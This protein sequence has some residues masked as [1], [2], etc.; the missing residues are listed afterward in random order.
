MRTRPETS[1]QLEL[2]PVMNLVAILIPMLLMGA[3]VLH[4]GV[5]D[6]T[7]PAI[8]P[9]GGEASE[10][11]LTVAITDRGLGVKAVPGALGAD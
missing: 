5:I 4:L 2:M 9:E 7:A 10:L 11:R 6:S 8:G 3:Q 1:G